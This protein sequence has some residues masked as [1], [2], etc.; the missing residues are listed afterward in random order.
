MP[1]ITVQKFKNEDLRELPIFDQI[2]KRMEDVRLRAFE[3]FETR[4]REPGHELE[5]WLT[6]EREE[7]GGQP[8]KIA[9]S[10]EEYEF[11]VTLAGFQAKQLRV[12][13]SPSEIIV[14]TQVESAEKPQEP[15]GMWTESGSNVFY[16][17]IELR[18][19]INVNKTT[20]VLDKE[21]L[22]ILAA[23]AVVEK[24]SSVAAA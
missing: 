4:G 6:A 17:R 20:A 10:D 24:R 12:I 18:Q 19:P 3:I 1:N 23:K 21:T 11:Q 16:R 22:R 13:A 2:E 5:D 9:E 14:H 7:L 8:F 15:N